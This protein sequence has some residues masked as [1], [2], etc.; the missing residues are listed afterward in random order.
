MLPINS[1]STE[2]PTS[3]A[4]TSISGLSCT[5]DLH[6]YLEATDGLSVKMEAIDGQSQRRASPPGH[7]LPIKALSSAHTWSRFAPLRTDK[8]FCLQM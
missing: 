8:L 4:S 3:A 2:Q 7:I 6:R 5:R 1:T